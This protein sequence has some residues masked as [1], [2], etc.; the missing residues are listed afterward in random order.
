MHCCVIRDFKI[1]EFHIAV[2]TAVS[3]GTIYI[4]LLH[5]LS[6]V[7]NIKIQQFTIYMRTYV[8]VSCKIYT[9]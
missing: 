5:L 3:Q 4:E 2:Y 7:Q 9:S 8:F 6:D 1:S